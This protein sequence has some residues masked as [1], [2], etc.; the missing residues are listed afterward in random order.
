[1]TKIEIEGKC[2]HGHSNHEFKVNA[3]S[4]SRPPDR[5]CI[6]QTQGISPIIFK[7]ERAQ[8]AKCHALEIAQKT[9][10]SVE[11]L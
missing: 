8:A 2:C 3:G 5:L 1:M 4:A 9:F 7:T 11:Q 6:D 10:S